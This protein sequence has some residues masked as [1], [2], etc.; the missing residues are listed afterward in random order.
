VSFDWVNGPFGLDAVKGTTVPGRRTVLAVAHHVTAG[1]RLAEVLPLLESDR[2]I[3]VVYTA[4]PASVHTGGLAEYL[5]ALGGLVVPWDQAARIR[6]DLAIAASHGMLENLHAPILTLPHGSGPGKLF[7]RIQ[8]SGPQA[9]RPVTGVLPER[10][11]VG[12]RVVPS[13][14]ILPHERHLSLLA[15]E[16]PEALSVAVVAGD[17]CFDRLVASAGRRDAYRHAFGVRPGQ[18]LVFVTSTWGP[19]SLFGQHP[20]ALFRVATELPQKRFC[21]VAAL[22]P[23]IWGW[24]GRRQVTRWNADSLRLGVR[25]LPPEEGWRAALIAADRIIGDHGSVTYYGAAMSVPVL[26][27]T[28]PDEDVAPDSHNARLAAIAPRVDWEKPLR[29]QLEDAARAYRPE[30]HLSLR[31]DLSSRPGRSAELLRRTMYEL[32]RLPEPESPPRL[33]P[34]PVPHPIGHDRLRAA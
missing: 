9:R 3:Q 23:H 27:G 32:M 16:C 2:R 5:D 4:A 22:H 14:L 20:D 28:F 33:D 15:R 26:L 29:P 10:L 12:G 18:Q 17:P 31:N 24:N 11:V 19:Q 6:F 25:L 13:A 30:I 8:G 7:G 21:V 1:T 34:V